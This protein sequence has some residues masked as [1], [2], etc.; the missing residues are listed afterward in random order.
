MMTELKTDVNIENMSY[1]VFDLENYDNN[2]LLFSYL[3]ITN[4]GFRKASA[5]KQLPFLK[6]YRTM[7]GKQITKLFEKNST[8][9]NHLKSINKNFDDLLSDGSSNVDS[10][11]LYI[12]ENVLKSKYTPIIYENESFILPESIIKTTQYIFL[13]KQD[14]IYYPVNVDSK[15]IFTAED[16]VID[17]ISLYEKPTL[18]EIDVVE[19]PDDVFEDNVNVINDTIDILI[20]DESEV[21]I[22]DLDEETLVYNHELEDVI[23]EDEYDIYINNLFDKKQTIVPKFTDM[24]KHRKRNATDL[25][26]MF[27]KSVELVRKIDEN[28]EEVSEYLQLMSQFKSKYVWKPFINSPYLE[29]EETANIITND[30]NVMVR[31]YIGN[32]NEENSD[33]YTCIKDL[34]M[35]H[36]TSIANKHNIKTPSNKQKLCKTLV[37]HNFLLDHMILKYNNNYS[38]E[39]LLSIAD[40]H[41]PPIDL[42]TK[43][44]KKIIS[45]LI[46]HDALPHFCENNLLTIED[47]E[48]IADKHNLPVYENLYYAC[49]KYSNFNLLVDSD[50]KKSLGICRED[51]EML[52]FDVDDVSIPHEFEFSR[53]LGNDKVYST[54]LFFRNDLMSSKI[55]SF[56]IDNYIEVLKNVDGYLPTKCTLKYYKDIKPTEKNTRGKIIEFND[57]V[58]KI[59]LKDESICYYNLVN[60]S[61]NNC[62]VYTKQHESYQFN[63]DDILKKNVDIVSRKLT[64]QDQMSLIQMTLEEY[65]FFFNPTVNNSIT[66]INNFLSKFGANLLNMDKNT[67]TMLN[68]ILNPIVIEEPM[69]VGYVQ[70]E[71]KTNYSFYD[72]LENRNNS[73]FVN[74]LDRHIA[75]VNRND[76]AKFIF[77][78]NSKKID[79]RIEKI[80]DISSTRP[81]KYTGVFNSK[82]NFKSF[83]DLVAYKAVVEKYMVFKKEDNLYRTAKTLKHF[84]KHKKDLLAQYSVRSTYATAFSSLIHDRQ[85]YVSGKTFIHV[86]HDSD[87]YEGDEITEIFMRS[88]GSGAFV[89]EIFAGQEDINN[90]I[91]SI[92]WKIFGLE[93]HASGIPYKFISKKLPTYM[94][95]MGKLLIRSHVAKYPDQKTLKDVFGQDSIKESLWISSSKMTIYCA[96]ITILVQTR[97]VGIDTKNPSYKKAFTTDGYPITN[98]N[99]VSPVSF[100]NYLAFLVV[101]YFGKTNPYFENENAFQKKIQT[102]IKLVLTYEPEIADV[103]RVIKDK[104]VSQSRSNSNEINFKP[105]TDSY[106]REYLSKGL[107]NSNV[108]PGYALTTYTSS[109]QYSMM[110]K[111]AL[112]Q[113]KKPSKAID[114]ISHIELSSNIRFL[115]EIKPKLEPGH[116]SNKSNELDD[117]IFEMTNNFTTYF[118]ID[119]QEFIQIFILASDEKIDP[120]NFTRY[121]NSNPILVRIK[122][123][124]VDSLVHKTR[125]FENVVERL[126]EFVMTD[127]HTPLVNVFKMFESI[128]N[129]INILFDTEEPF[130]FIDYNTDPDYEVLFQFIVSTIQSHINDIVIFV[131]KQLVSFDDLVLKKSEFRDDA[132][133]KENLKYDAFEPE[134]ISIIKA[135]QQIGFDVDVRQNE[136]RQDDRYLEDIVHGQ[137]EE[138]PE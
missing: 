91:L 60:I 16:D 31:S 7:L 92:L 50:S 100:T 26:T 8:F 48:T 74:D 138:I 15:Y 95:L 33:E 9:S 69:I 2:E 6:K 133:L 23:P 61:N 94:S 126:S 76:E 108:S 39:E 29:N 65:N 59:K 125:R 107:S 58:L 134:D 136:S 37:A 106:I 82:N 19:E 18:V 89:A 85:L 83:E 131:K 11:L 25:Q 124:I 4:D 120:N 20:V 71:P 35:S 102:I 68:N 116:E 22:F 121:I 55:L 52:T 28:E 75:L 96:F 110:D 57:G 113:I 32:E 5:R 101:S 42:T 53:V 78:F 14:N 43:N 135:L 47:F 112:I 73:M 34:S 114:I 66:E 99:N 64:H 84:I 93:T 51:V 38:V 79:N 80:G 118:K 54:G 62:F 30:D 90:D 3:Y 104:P 70:T 88:D 117:S 97:V 122:G 36:I 129:T 49:Q 72:K 67:H 86:P 56:D 40:S 109:N 103:L 119:L 81:S 10:G 63:K 13:H 41:S 123:Y 24:L 1:F 45:I 111:S 44:K 87:I 98:T 115:D 137:D 21:N 12:F 130:T 128:K 77:E 105:T 127:S 132:R 27:F 46:E 17:I